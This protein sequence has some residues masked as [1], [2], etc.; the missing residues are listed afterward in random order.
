MFNHRSGP[1]EDFVFIFLTLR[2]ALSVVRSSTRGLNRRLKSER[3][4]ADDA[5]FVSIAVVCN[6]LVCIAK[7]NLLLDDLTPLISCTV[8]PSK[9]KKHYRT[10]D[11]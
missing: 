3:W 11:D 1:D 8:L 4:A 5:K 9:V 10:Q 6:G 7:T 2:P